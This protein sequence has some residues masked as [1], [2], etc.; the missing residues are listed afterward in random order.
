MSQHSGM[1]RMTTFVF[2]IIPHILG[3]MRQLKPVRDWLALRQ[4]QLVTVPSVLCSW[5]GLYASNFNFNFNS[6]RL[7]QLS[8]QHRPWSME[9]NPAAQHFLTIP[10]READFSSLSPK[11]AATKIK[12]C[13]HA[14]GL[15][16]AHHVSSQW[17]TTSSYYLL[18]LS[19]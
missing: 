15:P 8:T 17:H 7:S 14:P 19:T 13:L 6:R 12:E 11:L 5:V 16:E 4:A 18:L 10:R 2:E 3:R 9:D 1:S